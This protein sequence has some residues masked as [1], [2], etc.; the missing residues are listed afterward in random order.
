MRRNKQR[1]VVKMMK[2]NAREQI[3]MA[4][5]TGK[6]VPMKKRD[7]LEKIIRREGRDW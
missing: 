6:L 1:D 5:L 4:Q 2:A 7:I 3:P